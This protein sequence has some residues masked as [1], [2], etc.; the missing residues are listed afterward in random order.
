MANCIYGKFIENTNKYLTVKFAHTT[1]AL[2][3]HASYPRF[4]NFLIISPTLVAV[5]L[6]SPVTKVKQAFGI[7]LSILDLSKEFMYRSYY[8]HVVNAF[9]G[10]CEV[11]MSDTDSLFFSTPFCTNP[12]EKLLPILDTSNFEANHPL[13]CLEN[14]SRLGYFKSET[15]STLVS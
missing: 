12:F 14:K 5:F 9:D 11:L 3:K 6:K 8:D 10:R 4:M 13:A 7:G 15:G 1:H 2:S